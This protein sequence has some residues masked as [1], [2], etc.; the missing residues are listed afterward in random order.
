MRKICSVFMAF[1]MLMGVF[2]IGAAAIDTE[3]TPIDLTET[4]YIQRGITADRTINLRYF[5]KLDT[6]DIF[7]I[8]VNDRLFTID[9][10]G[11]ITFYKFAAFF[12]GTT[13]VQALD[14]DG[15]LIGQTKVIVTW[16]WFYYLISAIP[17]FTRPGRW[18]WW[19]I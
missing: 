6:D 13:V 7:W 1:L 11:V 8:V 15:D 2:A 3:T 19:L 18:I 17:A 12:G 16:K 14:K 5:E 4:L 9:N 10:D